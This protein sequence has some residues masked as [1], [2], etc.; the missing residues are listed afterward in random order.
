[1]EDLAGES[2]TIKLNITVTDVNEKPICDKKDINTSAT[3]RD[4]IDYV[5]TILSCTDDDFS[6]SFKTLEYSLDGDPNTIGKVERAFVNT[7][8]MM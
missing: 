7:K 8:I 3:V 1:M 4:A 6:Q 2:D 5:V